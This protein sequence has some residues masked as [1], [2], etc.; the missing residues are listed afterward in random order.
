MDSIDPRLAGI[1][2]HIAPSGPAPGSAVNPK[3]AQL[4]GPQPGWYAVNVNLLHGDAWP[5]RDEY[6]ELGFYG[7]FLEFQP[8]ARAGY[9][10]YIYHLSIEDVDRVRRRLQL[11]PVTAQ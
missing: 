2:Y 5:G 3:T 11:P 7:Y 8:V 1:D 9:S 6:P 4:L 10:I